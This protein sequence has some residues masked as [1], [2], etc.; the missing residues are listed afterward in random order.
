[1][2][3]IVLALDASAAACSV[4]LRRGRDVLAFREAPMDRGHAEALMPLVMEAMAEA[5]LG[6]A[7]LAMVAVGV[8]PGSF[9]GIRIALAAARGIGLAAGRPVVGV[10][11]FSAV[12][13]SV[14]EAELSGRS[15]LVVIESKRKE[16]FGQ[17]FDSARHSLGEALVL[18]A[19]ELLLY[20]PQGPLVVAGDGAHYLREATDAIFATLAGRPDARAIAHLAA[21]GRAILA[22]RPLYL[23]GAD[24][25]FPAGK[26]PPSAT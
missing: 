10:D 9:T 16:L 21:E 12:A 23:R 18:P 20:R 15:L 25:T 17:Y 3:G 22:P 1:V 11:S 13:A 14:G 7:D 2:S 5:R 26:S 4:A 8:G 24:V 6:F 19:A